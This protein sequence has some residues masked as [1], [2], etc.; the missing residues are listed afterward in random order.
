M[1]LY[2]VL[3]GDPIILGIQNQGFL[4][5]VLRLLPVVDPVEVCKSGGP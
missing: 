1:A 2:R 3:H 4:Q 5:E